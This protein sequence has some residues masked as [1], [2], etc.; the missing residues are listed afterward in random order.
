MLQ[1]LVTL[2]NGVSKFLTRNWAIVALRTSRYCR[3]DLVLNRQVV[4]LRRRGWEDTFTPILSGTSVT[5]EHDSLWKNIKDTEMG[6]R[7]SECWL[8]RRISLWD[9]AELK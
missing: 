1:E 2:L 8:I 5:A 4:R 9:D 6:N 7:L 3:H